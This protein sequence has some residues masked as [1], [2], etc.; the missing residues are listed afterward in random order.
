MLVA[1]RVSSN[2]FSS[3]LFLT[4]PLLYFHFAAFARSNARAHTHM[5][6]GLSRTLFIYFFP[7]LAITS[8]YVEDALI[9]NGTLPLM[10]R[11]VQE[12]VSRRI[13]ALALMVP[14]AAAGGCLINKHSLPSLPPP[15]SRPP[16]DVLMAVVFQCVDVDSREC[17]AK[18]SCFKTHRLDCYFIISACLSY[19]GSITFTITLSGK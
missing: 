18:H 6:T 16:S 10:P 15:L 19:R 11:G 12:N 3:F 8:H 9:S 13:S 4:H 7:P 17:F 14:A 2:V 1:V 5:Q